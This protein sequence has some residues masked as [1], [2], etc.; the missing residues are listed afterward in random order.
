M[1]YRRIRMSGSRQFAVHVRLQ[2]AGH[3]YRR[4]QRWTA[5]F[6]PHL[7]DTIRVGKSD[8][9]NQPGT[10]LSRASVSFLEEHLGPV[11]TMTRWVCSSRRMVQVLTWVALLF[12]VSR[13]NGCVPSFRCRRSLPM[14]AK[15]RLTGCPLPHSRSSVGPAA[16]QL[17]LDVLCDYNGYF[18]RR[19]KSCRF[20]LDS[21]EFVIQYLHSRKGFEPTSAVHWEILGTRG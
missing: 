10:K 5:R 21:D 14:A 17:F 9:P 4:Q 3:Q 19:R 12:P 16:S 1:C 13:S 20:Y 11:R 6:L 15:P 2:F 8:V 18:E 7:G